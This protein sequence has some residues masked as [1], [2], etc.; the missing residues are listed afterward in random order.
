M[1]RWNLDKSR[2]IMVFLIHKER[3]TGPEKSLPPKLGG[4]DCS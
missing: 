4:V 1:I 2:I 3:Q